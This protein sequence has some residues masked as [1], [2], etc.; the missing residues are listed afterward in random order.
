MLTAHAA[1]LIE[2]LPSSGRS[3]TLGSHFLFSLRGQVPIIAHS[4]C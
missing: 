3:Q 2:K 4:A 1:Y